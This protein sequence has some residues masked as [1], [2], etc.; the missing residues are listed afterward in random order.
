LQYKLPKPVPTNE[1]DY[2][3]FTNE[4]NVGPISYSNS[5]DRRTLFVGQNASAMPRVGS[6]LTF[7]GQLQAAFSIAVQLSTGELYHCVR[8]VS[9]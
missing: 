6:R 3:G 2:I 9:K 8:L 7:G 1:S 5:A 4:G